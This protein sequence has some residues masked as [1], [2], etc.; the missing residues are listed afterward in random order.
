MAEPS[1]EQLRPVPVVGRRSILTKAVKGVIG[2]AA[3]IV[4]SKLLVEAIG[5][6]R[7]KKL[8]VRSYKPGVL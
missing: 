6:R 7:D 1:S 5:E 2:T 4:G 8:F 3:A